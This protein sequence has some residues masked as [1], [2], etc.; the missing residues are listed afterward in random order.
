MRQAYSFVKRNQNFGAPEV[1]TESIRHMLMILRPVWGESE[2]VC[3]C[4]D[5]NEKFETPE[6]V[7]KKKPMFECNF[8]AAFIFKQ[9]SC[10]FL[11]FCFAKVYLA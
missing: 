9:K 1:A 6:Y 10:L 7:S 5:C 4:F 2:T 8:V 3:D 11:F